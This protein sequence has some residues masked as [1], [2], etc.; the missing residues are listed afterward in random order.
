MILFMS[1]SRL[2]FDPILS[3]PLSLNPDQQVKRIGGFDLRIGRKRFQVSIILIYCQVCLS[4]SPR[5]EQVWFVTD[6]DSVF[7]NMGREAEQETYGS[8]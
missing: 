2:N 7:L 1:L 3:Q 8:L 5:F 4:R 6:G